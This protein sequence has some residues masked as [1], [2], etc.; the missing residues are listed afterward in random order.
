M[1][2]IADRVLLG[3]IPTSEASWPVAVR[4]LKASGGWLHVH[5]NVRDSEVGWGREVVAPRIAALAAAAPTPRVW[6][7]V[8]RH[9]EVVKSYAPH[10]MHVVVDIECRVPGAAAAAAAVTAAAAAGV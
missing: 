3:L 8:C 9:T 2:G 5:G 6:D 7:V 4:L 1:N 10:V